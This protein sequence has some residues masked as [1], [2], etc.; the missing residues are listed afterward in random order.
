MRAYEQAVTVDRDG[1]VAVECL[2]V[3]AGD[4]VRVIVLISEEK[5]PEKPRY[6]LHGQPLRYEDP[7]E[8]VGTEDWEANE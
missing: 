8:P 2:P 1:V 3:K 5:Q 4:R 7:T 6:P